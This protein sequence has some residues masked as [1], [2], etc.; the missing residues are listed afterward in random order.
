M[1]DA[2]FKAEDHQRVAGVDDH[3]GS[4]VEVQLTLSKPVKAG[5][6]CEFSASAG[7]DAEQHQAVRLKVDFADPRLI[8]E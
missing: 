1:R 2:Q 8:E 6:L 4:R 7:D 3:L 5:L